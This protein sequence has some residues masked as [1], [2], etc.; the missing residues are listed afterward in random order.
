MSEDF[1]ELHFPRNPIMPGVLLLEALAQLAGWLEA[2]SSD[3]ERWFLLQKVDRCLF[4]GF[5]FPGDSVELEV[6]RD[7]EKQRYAGTCSVN[8]AKKV[9]AEFEGELVPLADLEE[10]AE[11]REFFKL[12]TRAREK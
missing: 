3:F 8:G 6:R 4:Y 1:L 2:G 11:R 7:G 9:L 12:L 5:A 10:P